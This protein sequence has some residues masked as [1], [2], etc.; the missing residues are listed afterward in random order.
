MVGSDVEELSSEGKTFALK[1]NVEWVFS[2]N[3]MGSLCRPIKLV[4]VSYSSLTLPVLGLRCLRKRKFVPFVAIILIVG[5]GNENNF[6]FNIDAE[7][8]EKLKWCGSFKARGM[9]TSSFNWHSLFMMSQQKG[10]GGRKWERC[11]SSSQFHASL[12]AVL[13]QRTAPYFLHL[14]AKNL[15]N[16][17]RKCKNSNWGWGYWNSWFLH[18]TSETFLVVIKLFKGLLLYFI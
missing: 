8:D 5:K 9:A 2:W 6:F 14:G 10:S 17:D 13:I 18:H 16:H 4:F 7:E 12:S 15:L 3:L 11:Y 1:K